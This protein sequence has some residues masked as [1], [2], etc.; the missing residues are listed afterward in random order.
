LGV[1]LSTAAPAQSIDTSSTRVTLGEPVA[2]T[3]RVRAFDWPASRLAPECLEARLQQGD[4][5]TEIGPLRLRTA[6]TG[7][8]GVVLVHLSSPDTV[9]E[10]VLQGRLMLRCGAEFMREFTV[11][12]DPPAE[13]GSRPHARRT[14]TSMRPKQPPPTAEAHPLPASP[15]A[16]RITRSNDVPTPR[17]PGT[18]PW[19]EQDLQRL[20]HLVADALQPTPAVNHEPAGGTEFAWQDLR[21]EQQQARV[22]LAALQSRLERTERD[23]WRDAAIV[24]G[25]LAGLA[26]SLL[27]ARGVREAT[28]PRWRDIEPRRT[29]STPNRQ[30]PGPTPLPIQTEP[31]AAHMTG[32]AT[33]PSPPDPHPAAPA[34]R[35]PAHADFGHPTLDTLASADLRDELAAHQGSSPIAC[36][37]ALEERLQDGEAKCPWILLDLLALYGTLEQPWNQERVAAQLG[38]LYNVDIDPRDTRTAAP[39]CNDP[40]LTTHPAAL[41]LT[42]SAWQQDDPAA[43]LGRLLLRETAPSTAL[44]LP[45]FEEVLLLHSMALRLRACADTPP[46]PSTP[47]DDQDRRPTIDWELLAA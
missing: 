25:T 46:V 9:H 22:Q 2:M 19:N 40:G 5:G 13:A 11:L 44:D 21:A 18:A 15:P 31:P 29:A 34:S 6:P 10:P 27:V 8:D 23:P 12:A 16:E 24:A 41:A 1:L 36:I 20:A 45:A 4:Q 26:L 3:L 32:P 7:E 30:E 35:W 17:S 39:A 33:T 43:A 28:L 37:V 47:L 38:A 14:D 42:L